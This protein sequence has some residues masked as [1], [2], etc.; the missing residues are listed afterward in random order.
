MAEAL[1]KAMETFAAAPQQPADA[2]PAVPGQSRGGV[3]K[4]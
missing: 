1:R 4:C 3:P 2:A